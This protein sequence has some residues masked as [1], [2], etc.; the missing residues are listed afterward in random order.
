MVKTVLQQAKSLEWVPDG[1]EKEI[2]KLVTAQSDAKTA[3]VALKPFI[4]DLQKKRAANKKDTKPSTAARR[5]QGKAKQSSS[6]SSGPNPRMPTGEDCSLEECLPLLPPGARLHKDF[7]NN[8]W[9]AYYQVYT[10]SRSRLVRGSTDAEKE[11]ITFVW[12]KHTEITG[13][14]SP[15][16]GHG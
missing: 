3:T 8:R 9:R 1:E 15:S 16:V 7:S 5:T 13:E 11:V 14:S 2:D 10:I 12:Q 6:T 4:E